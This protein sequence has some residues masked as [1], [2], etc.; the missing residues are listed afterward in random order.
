MQYPKVRSYLMVTKYNGKVSIGS[1]VGRAIEIVDSDGVIF[2][3]LSQFNG[4]KNIE[5]IYLEVKNKHR[6]IH[7][8]DIENLI[9]K[10]NARSYIIEDNLNYMDYFKGG[11]NERHKRNINF[12][13]NFSPMGYEKY[14]YIDKIQ[15]QRVLL[16][17]LGGVGSSILYN[18]AALG[19]KE[20]IGLDFDKVDKTNLNRQILYREEDVGDYKV[21]AAKKTVNSFNS[22]IE[23]SIINKEITEEEELKEIIIQTSPTFIICAADRPAILLYDWLNNITLKYGIPWIYGGNSE[24]VSYYR[25]IEPKS[26]SCFKCSEMNYIDNNQHEAIEK[27]NYIKEYQPSPENN[28]IAASS[29]ILGSMMVID[30]MKFV[31]KMGSLKSDNSIIK[32][33]YTNME[34]TSRDIDRNPKCICS[35][36]S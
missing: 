8:E 4:D 19:V 30:Y 7:R 28:C 6:G 35:R 14:S 21:N 22:E 13:S 31:T 5:D 11:N 34:I 25:L 33:D 29:G 15:N 3:I 24:T 27:I 18:L 12:L 17:G 23:F 16:L 9:N 32:F 36:L 26:T 20:I 2:D 1:S 10:L